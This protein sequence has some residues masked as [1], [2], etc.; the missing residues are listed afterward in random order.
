MPSVEA[1]KINRPDGLN[2]PNQSPTSEGSDARRSIAMICRSRSSDS[3]DTTRELPAVARLASTI[4]PA[5]QPLAQIRR[6]PCWVRKVAI[7]AQYGHNRR[8]VRPP[9]RLVAAATDVPAKLSQLATARAGCFQ[10]RP[11]ELHSGR[12]HGSLHTDRQNGS[13]PPLLLPIA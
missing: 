12:G 1:S 7:P 3:Q 13:K 10:Q 6:Q 8:A 11:S 5:S 9:C 2:R 4:R